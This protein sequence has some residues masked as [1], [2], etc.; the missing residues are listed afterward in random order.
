MKTCLLALVV[1][2]LCI[3]YLTKSRM[4]A[5]VDFSDVPKT[6]MLC[7]LSRAPGNIGVEANVWFAANHLN[8][9]DYQ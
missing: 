3:P 4:T 1:V 9:A 6:F 5:L 7:R 8:I 2:F